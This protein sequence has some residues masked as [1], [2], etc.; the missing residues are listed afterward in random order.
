MCTNTKK[1]KVFLSFFSLSK[2]QEIVI[3]MRYSF[4]PL[5]I[6]PTFNA[7]VLQRPLKYTTLTACLKYQYHPSAMQHALKLCTKVEWEVEACAP[8]SLFN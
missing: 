4:Y 2:I 6:L 3:L 5:L 7:V 8:N 1:F